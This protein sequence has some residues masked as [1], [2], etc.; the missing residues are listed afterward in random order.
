MQR[1]GFEDVRFSGDLMKP[2]DPL[3][4][5]GYEEDVFYTRAFEYLR[6]RYAPEQPLFVY[7]AV[8]AHHYGFTRRAGNDAEWMLRD[9]MNKI[10]MYLESQRI[11]D[12]SLLTFDRLL[13]QYK[14]GKAHAFYVPD[15]SIPLGLYG[16]NAPN[17][18]ATIDNF[19][20]PFVYVPPDARA[21][22]LAVGRTIEEM[23]AQTD[24]VP[25]IAELVSGEPYP[26]SLVPF[27]RRDPQPGADY[28]RCHILSQPYSGKWLLIARG[29]A[30]YQFHVTSETFREFRLE[31]RPLRQTLVRQA[32]LSYE[33]LERR[34]GCAR[35]PVR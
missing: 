27:L 15:H 18:G 33:E 30:A 21:A 13:R 12:Q 34:Y 5:W 35:F 17:M 6:A 10:E 16:S 28:E 20:T 7:F 26:N 23:Y 24:L 31:G 3:T 11:Q 1:A 8:C 14:G 9:E 32:V 2:G 29:A 4:R 25:T 19:V 22:D